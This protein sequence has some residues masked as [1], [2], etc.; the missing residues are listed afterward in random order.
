MGLLLVLPIPNFPLKKFK[1]NTGSWKLHQVV[2]HH[3]QY[4]QQSPKKK[5]IT[6]PITVTMVLK[7]RTSKNPF[8]L[9]DLV[10]WSHPVL[11]ERRAADSMCF[12][13]LYG[14]SLFYIYIYIKITKIHQFVASFGVG[15]PFCQECVSGA[16]LL[17]LHHQQNHS[18]KL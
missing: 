3:H 9:L 15:R 18:L 2:W 11:W 14:S 5:K 10:I 8:S 1:P 6:P 17:L 7:K 4:T 16:R 13:P 12:R